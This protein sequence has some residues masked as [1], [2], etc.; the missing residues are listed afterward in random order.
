[1][2][3]TRR[4]IV[5]GP[6]TVSWRVVLDPLMMIA[7]VRA[8]ML[9]A[10][11]PTTMRGVWQNSD[12]LREPLE[13][14][15][16]TANFVAVTTVGTPEQAA[17]LGARVRGVHK[18]LRIE[19]PDTGR[20]HR[21]DDPELLLWVHCAEVSSYLEVIE[22]G[23]LKLTRAEKDRYYDEQRHTATYVGLHAEEVP[24][25]VAE[26]D[27]YF[28]AAR[29]DLD[30]R[31]I[32]ESRATVRFLL[33]PRVPHKLRFLA[34]LK[35]LWFPVGALAYYALPRWARDHY[36]A[37]PEFPGAGPLVGVGLRLARLGVI[38]V[39]SKLRARAFKPETRE[40]MADL[41]TRLEEC[42]IPSR[43]NLLRVRAEPDDAG[44][45]ATR[46]SA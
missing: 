8:L 33:W 15:F 11:Q 12:F 16:N 24:G 13:R 43:R 36:R 28:A 26:M 10:L 3:N 22:R 6:E 39:P 17:G 27:A 31:V 35:A 40:L 7:G 34:P 42:G 21:V 23:G 20:T 38:A 2:V 29:T 46:A 14:L 41:H 25:G 9:Q 32:P 5:H 30:L 19:D 4:L 45:P 37:L 1:M 18:R 44:A